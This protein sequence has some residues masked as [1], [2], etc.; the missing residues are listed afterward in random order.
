MAYQIFNDR[1]QINGRNTP[2]V[3]ATSS[4]G[5][6]H[7][8]VIVLHDTAD[9]PAPKDTVNYFCSAGC[10]VSAHVVV[11]RDGTI[12]QMV[13]FDCKA[14]HAGKSSW[15]G[16]SLVNGFGIGIEIDNPGMIEKNGRAWFHKKPAEYFKPEQIQHVK[17]PEHGDGYW[18]P[19]TP[20]QIAAVTQL[21]AALVAQYPTIKE[22]VTHYLISPNRKVDVNPLFPLEAVR[23]AVFPAV[24]KPAGRAPAFPGLKLGD[25]GDK[26]KAAQDK[27]AELG[28]PVGACDGQF[29]PQMRVAVLAFEAENGLQYDAELTPEE[30]KLLM[31]DTAA[32]AMPTGAREDLTVADLKAAGSTTITW[33]QRIKN[34]VVGL[35]LIGAVLGGGD[36]VAAGGAGANAALEQLEAVQATVAR[37]SSMFSWVVTP[38]G[39]IVVGIGLLLVGAYYAADKIEKARLKQAKNPNVIR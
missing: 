19:Y 4:G 23:T 11:E 38:T 37:T 7:P 1:L 32:K 13:D 21:C 39:L 10:K 22:I 31:T 6:F 15:G 2:F 28:Y 16:K 12:T 18:M 29:G 30:H 26:V 34:S 8:T 25:A 24:A 35:P 33:T 27:L 3:K 5:R 14:N 9:R 36:S 20:E 17:T